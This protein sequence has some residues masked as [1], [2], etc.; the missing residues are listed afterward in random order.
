M[1]FFVR[2]QPTFLA[3]C[4]LAGCSGFSAGLGSTPDGTVDRDQG[5]AA[6][7]FPPDLVPHPD[8]EPHPPDKL[9]HG[10]LASWPD[11]TPTQDLPLPDA[12][13]PDQT[14][15]RVVATLA[16]SGADG[17]Q[18]GASTIARFSFPRG[19]AVSSTGEVYV[20]D[21]GNHRIRVIHK[22]TV[23]T[24]AGCCGAGH[25]DGAVATARFDSPCGV[26]VDGV[27]RVYVA[28]TGNHRIRVIENGQ[29]ITLAGSN[30]G[31]ADGLMAQARFSH[32]YS[33]ALGPTGALYVADRDNHRIRAV[34][35]GQVITVAGNGKMGSTNGQAH[36]AR[37][38]FPTGVAVD[39]VGTV[40][41]VDSWNHRIRFI[42]NGNVGNQA[43]SSY[44][45]ADGTPTAARFRYPHGVAADATGVYVG[46]SSNNRVRVLAGGH[47]STHAGQG[48]PNFADGHHA[49]AMFNN[50][51][52][53]ALDGAGRIYVADT[54]NH[55][56]RV[57][58][59]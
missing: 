30:K 15:I 2:A 8:V 14:Q 37:F 11:Q 12:A 41:V 43:G 21:T 23:S 45:F 57:I 29:V 48:T 44:G 40:F 25:Q 13:A 32:P 7:L 27:G 35:L 24:L 26:A 20:A 6:E 19:V 36:S 18:E 17:L 55:R 42:A 4:L 46:D 50:P 9:P 59:P 10:D 54:Q 51:R 39:A 52:G 3:A 47:V 34:H 33:L 31:F 16:G 49:L 38:R 1:K 22:G 56:I 53:L 58:S 5:A 28:D